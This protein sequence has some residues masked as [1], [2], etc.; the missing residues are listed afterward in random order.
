MKRIFLIA[1]FILF[2][3]LAATAQNVAI[4]TDGS[5]PN[6]SA[7][8]DI[9]SNSKGL[10]IPRMTTAEKAA[11]ASPANGLLIY[12]TDA[13]PGFYYYNG[14]AWTPVSNATA[15]SIYTAGTGIDV[16]GNTIAAKTTTALWNASQ[17][18]GKDISTTAPLQG[19]VMMFNVPTNKWGPTTLPSG[20]GSGWNLTGNG[21]IDAATNF[22]GT[23]DAQPFIGKAN[24]QQVFRFSSAKENTL[25]GYQ[26]SQADPT[27]GD[28]NHI[29]GYKAG[30]YNTGFNNHFDGYMAGNK[31]TSGYSNQ[32]IGWSAGLN[33][34]TGTDNLFMGTSAGYSNTIKS[35]LHFIGNGAGFSNTTG[36]NN[37][38]SG[39]DAGENN[40][41]GSNNHFEGN[42]AGF[43]NTTG[44]NNHFVGYNAGYANTQGNDNYF[45]GRS[46]GKNNSFG[47]YNVF[48][49]N[50]AGLSNT[51]GTSNVFTGNQAGYLHSSGN[52]NVLIGT[53][54]GYNNLS[55]SRNL[56]LGYKAGYNETGDDKL[57]I[58][59]SST[60]DPLIYGNFSNN[61]LKV[62]GTQ[63]IKATQSAPV[64]T[65][66]G[67]GGDVTT[68][69][70]Q[71]GASSNWKITSYVGESELL[72]NHNNTLNLFSM[73]PDGVLVVWDHV[74]E[75]SDKSLKKN[76]TPLQSPLQKLLKLNGYTYNW[77]DSTKS[78][79][80]QIGL[81]AQ[82]VEAQF[83]QL[84]D[85]QKDGIKGVA[86]THMVP[87]LVESIKEQQTMIEDLKTENL[88]LKK[89]IA[90]IKSK[91]SIQ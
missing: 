90:A 64:L 56:F 89:D 83:P 42:H 19:Q 63:E 49:G 1:K 62:N 8:L 60:N 30:F 80:Q 27:G 87:V 76:I 16:T 40:T 23:T 50:E 29:I 48:V 3:G 22:I 11:I 78:K 82:E 21:G 84:I 72:F 26:A 20:S 46:A 7:M 18:Q 45:S 69:K 6:A 5:Q 31:N 15:A 36:S 37:H 14:T 32:F 12:Q 88:Q 75:L 58:A 91:L 81:I 70:F 55:G 68:L 34:T 54:T 2:T 57:Y 41:T 44:S 86:Y 38:F 25:I 24:G 13:T 4:N 61:S 59:N 9:K 47:N 74:V 66:T 53:E 51:S 67:I 33:N 52:S 79:G 77:I 71:S 35:G 85:T 73:H 39:F 10:L 43:G 28:K 65:L 17:L